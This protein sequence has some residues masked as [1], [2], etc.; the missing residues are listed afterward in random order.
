LVALSH[1]TVKSKILNYI[2]TSFRIIQK[3]RSTSA[4]FIAGLG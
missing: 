4:F 3:R 2:N 1:V